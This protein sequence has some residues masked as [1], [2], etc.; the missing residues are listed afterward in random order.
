MGRAGRVGCRRDL[1]PPAGAAGGA[2]ESANKASAAVPEVASD[3]RRMADEIRTALIQSAP[4]AIWAIDLEGRVILWNPAAERIFGWAAP[5]VMGKTLPM[6]GQDERSEFQQ[7]LER[8]RKGEP[9]SA[10]ERTRMRKDGSKVD[11][12]IW[13]APLHDASGAISGTLKLDADITHRKELEE[14]FR[15]SQKLE[16]IGRLAGGVA[17][18]FNNLLTVILGYSGMLLETP[19]SDIVQEYGSEIQSAASRASAL[20]AQMLAF[21]RK[22]L[23]QPRTVDMNDVITN[24]AKLLGR[25]IGEDIEL[26]TRL[27]PGLG[28]I[29]ADPAHLDQ[30]IMNLAVNARDAM[31][32]GGRLTIET[33]NAMLDDSY[34]EIHPEVKPGPYVMLAVSDTGVG[35]T[36]E[37]RAR[38]FEPFFTTK[39]AGKGT[40]L[41]LSIVYG[42]VK[43]N[44]GELVVYSEP[45][46]G[47]SFK[48]YFPMVDG[49]TEFHA[50]H[51]RASELRGHET[52][53][54]CEDEDHIRRLVQAML[55]RQGYRVTTADRPERAL[56]AAEALGRPV[57]LLLTDIVMR[58]GS[59]FALADAMRQR[60]PGLKVLYMS[61][62]ADSR[63]EGVDGLDDE[64]ARFLRKPF[65]SGDLALKVREALD[66]AAT[67]TSE[68][69][70]G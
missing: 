8:F 20:T 27:A 57:D 44:G 64:G 21:S 14:Q 61:G 37:V 41:G 31:S 3:D 69:E 32:G 12:A 4:L 18:D 2:A 53:L 13:T 63:V 46:G 68:E 55:E 33:A 70:A 62:Y 30:V 52:I 66:V 17:H 9:M 40:G 25:L 6:I 22:Q 56:E 5:E 50:A 47:A 1:L 15:Q 42:I 34:T 35:M 16:A 39:E 49:H 59:G 23:T 45:G 19:S 51:A 10:V 60:Q 67:E 28:K 43:Q 48:L 54:V 26:V 58:T 11:V 7:W 38:L 24:A 65:A 29:K 36:P